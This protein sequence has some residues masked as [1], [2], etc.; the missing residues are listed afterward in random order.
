[1]SWFPYRTK[2]RDRVSAPLPLSAPSLEANQRT[3]LIA[4][5]STAIALNQLAARFLRTVAVA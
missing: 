1:M 3:P 2:G 5:T 4:M